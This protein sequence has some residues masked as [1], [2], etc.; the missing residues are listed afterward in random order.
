MSW[1]KKKNLS[2][3]QDKSFI[4][5]FERGFKRNGSREIHQRRNLRISEDS[6]LTF[7]DFFFLFLQ[8]FHTKLKYIPVTSEGLVP[9][10]MSL[11]YFME[12]TGKNRKRC[13]SEVKPIILNVH[14]STNLRL[15]L[16]I[17]VTFKFFFFFN[18]SLFYFALRLNTDT[19]SSQMTRNE[20]Q[21][22]EKV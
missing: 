4:F 10:Q 11:L 14:K 12:K 22:V 20:F 3:E 16:F 13:G 21:S 17:L 6:C 19:A 18:C 8:R 2:L 1:K 9:T 5:Y 7:F 15:V